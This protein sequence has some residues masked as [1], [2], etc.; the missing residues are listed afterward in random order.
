MESIIS[1]TAGVAKLFMREHELGKVLPGYYADL[2][3]VDGQPLDDITVLQDHSKLVS[4]MINGH[5]HKNAAA[6]ELVQ[7]EGPKPVSGGDRLTN[8]V[9]YVANNEKPRIGHLDLEKSTITP[10]A[11]ISG[12]PITNL[13]QV[14]E[15]K[16]AVKADGDSI[17]LSSVTLQAPIKDRDIL[18][19][20]KNYAEHAAEFNRS[21]Y[22]SS[23]KVDQREW[24]C[25][26]LFSLFYHRIW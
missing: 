19:V 21:G 4:I 9:S 11:M 25:L 1:A 10:L 14:I 23:D 18:A 3:L 24:P 22:D 26:A 20:G 5:L 2:I 17:P 13:Y 7:G 12:A 15:L 8:F 6:N 16:N